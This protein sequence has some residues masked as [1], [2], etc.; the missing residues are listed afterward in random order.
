MAQTAYSTFTVPEVLPLRKVGDAV[1]LE[2]FWGPTAA[3]KGNHKS[4]H[5]F[6]FAFI[7]DIGMRML[8]QFLNY[9]LSR[10]NAVAN[11]LVETSGDTGPAAV[12][13]FFPSK[14][15]WLC[16]NVWGGIRFYLVI[17]MNIRFWVQGLKNINVFCMYPYGKVSRVQE[18]SYLFPSVHEI[19]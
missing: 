11:V 4:I 13:L 17:R 15:F 9:F 10:Q 8:A 6:R 5:F 19:I 18:V 7:W 16:K 1:I 12:C 3:F 14:K 2:T